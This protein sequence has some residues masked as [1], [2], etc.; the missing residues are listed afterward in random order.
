MRP[1]RRTGLPA[2]V[3]VLLPVLAPVARGDEDALPWRDRVT[4][5]A[6]DRVR[7]ELVDWFRPP[8]GATAAGA[9]R[10][11]FVANQLR[12]GVRVV[13]PHAEVFVEAQDT[14]LAGLPDDASLPPPI[15]N[16]GTGAVYFANTHDREQGETFLKQ[17]TLTL[18]RAGGAL[19]LGRFEYRDGLEVVPAD[20]TLAFVARTRVAERLVGTFD[21][22]HVTRSFDGVRVAWDRPAW[23]LTGVAT[24][25]T[26]G[27]F[28]V[29][30]NRELD[31]ILAGVAATLRRLPFGPPLEARVFWLYYED[32]RDALKVDDRPLP[33]RAA[34]HDPIVVHSIGGDAIAAVD[35]G[36]GIVDLLAWS[37][38][39]TGAWG[40]DHH[41]AWAYALEA[42]YQLPRVPAS[43]WLRVGWDRSSGDGDPN[44][45]RHGTFFQLLPTARTYAQLPFYDLMNDDDVFTELLLRPHERLLLRTDWHRLRV[46]EGRDLWYSGG[47]ATN[48]T[49]FGFA[50]SPARGHRNLAQVVDVSATLVLPWHATLGA[51][52]G[53]AFGGAVVG[54]TFVGRDAD[55]GFVEAT[56]RY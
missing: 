12:L 25:P 33:V 53:H 13:L 43:P 42:G 1:A 36:P 6:S 40:V 48:D 10:Y 31:V 28:E 24:R 19:T 54:A 11:A 16:L 20:P 46:T 18:R 22:T 5:T 51:Y 52:Y 4:L 23:N 7:G 17:G 30:A 55:Y 15:G 47:G 26:M 41:A 39:Q 34:D 3:V 44:D 37:V 35:A 38:A 9:Q 2:L 45:R 21:F 49:L 14:R 32:D 8:P 27:G 29:S 50:G 56:F